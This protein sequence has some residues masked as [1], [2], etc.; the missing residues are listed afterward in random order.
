M[1]KL[2]AYFTASGQGVT[3]GV[4]AKL[5]EAVGAALY[6][7]CPAVPY[8]AE[9]LDWRV[10]TSRST[11]E[12]K[13]KA[14]RPALK[15]TEAP[16]ADAQIV[17]IGYP[18]WW[19]REPSVVDTFAEA[20]DFTGKK[21]ALFATSGSSDIGREAAERIAEITGAPVVAAKRFAADVS[22][23]ELKAWAEAIG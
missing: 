10:Q 17:F 23:E 18:V 5:A 13:D 16:V 9:D 4:A 3:A 20:Y 22:V 21:I 8:T 14:C 7:I 12:M 19:Y 1:S 6:E 11:L 15:D 2:V